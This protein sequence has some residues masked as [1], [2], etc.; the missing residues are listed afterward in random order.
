MDILANYMLAAQ[1]ILANSLNK[2]LRFPILA[3][4]KLARMG[5]GL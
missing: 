3:T 5:H 2:R 1:E 4:E